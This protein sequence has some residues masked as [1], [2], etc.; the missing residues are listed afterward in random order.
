MLYGILGF[1]NLL[2]GGFIGAIYRARHSSDFVVDS[3]YNRYGGQGEQDAQ[4]AYS[5]YDPFVPRNPVESGS[6]FLFYI[7]PLDSGGVKSQ[8]R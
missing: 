8:G 3:E 4:H 7:R 2:T 1:R 5:G 6:H